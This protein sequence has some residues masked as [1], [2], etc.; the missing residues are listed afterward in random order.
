MDKPFGGWGGSV[1]QNRCVVSPERGGERSNRTVCDPNPSH[2]LPNGHG[3]DRGEVAESMH[4]IV[5]LESRGFGGHL[6]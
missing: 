6:V 5:V 2:S 3:E 1:G 4:R